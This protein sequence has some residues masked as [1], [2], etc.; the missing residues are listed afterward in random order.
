MKKKRVQRSVCLRILGAFCT[1]IFVGLIFLSS[2]TS[3]SQDLLIE[4]GNNTAC[5]GVPC[6]GLQRKILINEFMVSPAVNDGSI[7]GPGPNGGRGEWVELYNPDACNPADISCYILGNYTSEGSGGIRIPPNTIVPPSGFA[8]IRGVNAPAVP[9]N[10]LVAN[11]GNV[12]DIT[13]SSEITVPEVCVVG[14]PANRF[15]FPN[16][17]GWF[18]IYDQNGV[19]QDAVRWG[20]ANALALGFPP[21]VPSAFGCQ[22]PP[23]LMSYND[24]P[25]NRKTH[26]STTNGNSHIGQSIRRLT[27]GGVWN[28][29]G[30]P[31]FAACNSTCYST[32]APTCTGTATVISAPGTPPFFYSW[33]DALNQ[34]TAHA[35]GLCEGSYTVTITSGNGIVTLAEVTIGTHVPEL[36]LD[37]TSF[38]LN[39]G[40]QAL[41]GF[42]P[43]PT[44]GQTFSIS[45]LGVNNMQFNPS[46]AG[47]GSHPITF[48]LTDQSGCS[49]SV[50][51]IYTVHPVP[52]VSLNAPNALCITDSAVTVSTN[53]AGGTLSGPGISGSSFNPGM[54]GVGTHQIQFT[55]TDPN[56]CTNPQTTVLTTTI[57]V[58]GLT[59]PEFAASPSYCVGD[60]IPNFPSTSLNNISGSWSPAINNQQ[61]TTY[62]FTPSPNQCAQVA[63]R[64]LQ[65]NPILT[66]T[67]ASVGPF[68]DGAAI[69][70]FPATSLNGVT[71]AWSPT[72]NNTQTTT[73]TFTPN[74]GNCAVTTT[75]TVVVNPI[76]TPL[77]SVVGP[78]CSG[79]TIPALPISSLNG[80]PGTWSPIINNTQ[81]A[82]YTFTPAPSACAVSSFMEV[83][84]VSGAVSLSCPPTE[85]L[86]CYS[87]IA[88]P[89]ADFTTFQNSGGAIS[90]STAL[91]VANTV[92]MLSEAGTAQSCNAQV[93]RVYQFE[94]V[95]G[96]TA[97]CSQIIFVN[98]TIS[99]LGVAP[100]DTLIQCI[101]DLPLPN[102]SL[103]TNLSD[104]CSAPTVVHLSDQSSGSCPEIILRTY[105][106]QDACGNFSDVTQ[107][108]TVLDTIPPTG[109][110][111]SNLFVQ[112]IG[113][114][115][116]PNPNLVINVADNC[117]TPVVSHLTDNSNNQTCPEV[118]SR[119]YR[120]SDACGNFT[121]LIQTI[122]IWDTIAPNGTPPPSLV[123]DCVGDVP[124]PNPSSVT[125]TS[126]NC[127][128]PTVMHVS[129]VSSGTCPETITRTYRVE[130]ACGNFTD[131]TQL[132][133][134][135]DSIPPT[136]TAPPNITVSCPADI[137]APNGNTVTNLSDNC[138]TVFVTH[139]S[140]I[141][142]N[143]FCNLEVI[144]RTYRLEDACGNE[145]FV[146][147]L[148]TV[149]L[150]T[151]TASL[152]FSNPTTC[153]GTEGFITVAGLYSNTSYSI[154]YN[155][156]MIQQE[157]NSQGVIQINDLAQGTYSNFVVA[158]SVCSFCSQLINQTIVLTDPPNPLVSAG[159]DV[160]FCEGNQYLV[161]AENP[162]NAQITWSDN[163]QN[164]TIIQPPVG[165]NVYTVT[166]VL[167]N[168]L[169]TDQVVITV[170][171]LPLVDAG[172]DFDVCFGTSIVLEGS[173]AQTYFWTNNVLDGEPFFQIIP[174]QTYQVTG[175]NQYGCYSQDEV[176]ITLL[177]NPFPTFTQDAF[178]S[179]EKPFQVTFNN[180][181][182]FDVADCSW[183][184]GNNTSVVGTCDTVVG[185]FENVG[186]YGLTLTATYTNGC[187]NSVYSDSVVCV[188]PTPTAQFFAT[189]SIQE[190]NSD[191]F[192]F[193]AS[194][195]ATDYF[196][197]FNPDEPPFLSK[198]VFFQFEES[199]EYEV[200]LVAINE[201]GCVDS[202]TQMIRVEN[203]I[204]LFVPNAFTPDGDAFNNEFKPVM[205]TGFD[206]YNYEL[207]IFNR[208]GEVLFVSRNAN[209][210]WPG[211]YGGKLVPEGI[212]IW[213]I[214]VKNENGIS[215]IHRGHVS[216]LK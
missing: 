76:L 4:I 98:D 116:S 41:S 81:T 62:I 134:V 133:T 111:P 123:V 74:S 66:P 128:L 200:I 115:P 191:I 215:E 60:P 78:F 8:V 79:E 173:G 85:S 141:S 75:S 63:T 186:C 61:T 13:I 178:S 46:S 3:F 57:T 67:F 91:L 22:N 180:T 154:T 199:G 166:A 32:T 58:N 202:A 117:S 167:N 96:Q 49:N 212:Y 109:T 171:P 42:S 93:T 132:I 135:L 68:C 158:Y 205:A 190:V 145:S 210:G 30:P 127:T 153:Q 121:D 6:G 71:G 15:W 11:G 143:N 59:P 156:E 88:S 209:F 176:E 103:V 120:I 197:Y 136:G 113:D 114:V 105:R 192:F 108:I 179:C 97:S 157:S 102:S 147:H 2:Q 184:F 110:A 175:I 201:Y 77:F 100:N 185:V 168:C 17:G 163:I 72:I 86:S 51:S 1:L 172:A 65:V 53:P 140:D 125:N 44:P 70:G 37:S 194:Q 95:C 144:T 129:D 189:P 54:A 204:L 34:N 10:A 16:S 148:I 12:V 82:T 152:S 38:C 198:D 137:P 39:T 206:P 35:I 28:A 31:T 27:D 161:N 131:L 87:E 18:A 170:Y 23:S 73:Y 20:T 122:T 56:G 149:D 94:N 162:E 130:D 48:S 101:A 118:I 160:A 45:G 181:T 43:T 213:Q 90:S 146:S 29:F 142:D 33:N 164:G 188:L 80:V 165:L 106:I 25:L 50:Q 107:T 19:P 64:T 174:F 139:F 5:Q 40:I 14:N 36:I 216:L 169:S 138:Q 214:D 7:S 55:Y 119:I 187:V 9:F 83:V 159:S 26:A 211:T 124:N 89:I 99:P 52:V 104:N 207:T 195:N 155:T 183:F 150:L 126:D 208:S 193:N 177:E 21:C 112:C 69:P 182:L 84:V 196:W 151:P 24:I 47:V 92:T 203:P